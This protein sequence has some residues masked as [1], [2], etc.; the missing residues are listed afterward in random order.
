MTTKFVVTRTSAG[1]EGVPCEGLTSEQRPYVDHRT[2]ADPRDLKFPLNAEQDWY[3]RGSNHRVING[4]IA[5]D[6]D[7]RKVW[8]KEFNS[9]EELLEFV[10][11]VGGVV[12]VELDGEGNASIEIYDDYRE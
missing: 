10:K 1:W 12:V 8:T 5:R 6:M 3:A 11:T 4:T 9:L 2:V 7:M